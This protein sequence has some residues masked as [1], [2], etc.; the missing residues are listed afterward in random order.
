LTLVINFHTIEKMKIFVTGATGFVGSHLIEYFLNRG[1]TEII[2]LVRNPDNL[3]WLKGLEIGVSKG[4][5]FHIPDL[6]NDIDYVFHIAGLT[7]AS[8]MAD[9]YTVNQQGTA[10]LFRSLIS[11]GLKPKKVICL[12]SIAVSGPS[13]GLVPVKEESSPAPMTHYGKSKLEG[14]MEARKYGDA[15]PV[16]ILRVGAVYGPRDRDFLS[17]FNLVKKG[18]LPL[19][20][21]GKK[22]ISL[23]YVKD[24]AC[25][26]ELTLE[27]PV[28]G[29]TFHIADPEPYTWEEIGRT[30]GRLMGKDRIR[31][32]YIPTAAAYPVVYLSE[33]IGKL[34]SS[35]SI[36]NSQKLKEG[37]QEAWI[38]DVRKA[39]E[40]LGYSPLYTLQEGLRET[41]EWY[42]KTDWL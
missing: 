37:L 11:Q 17:L 2:A 26:F 7:K 25:A 22:W 21:R 28:F 14:E 38:V 39:K 10:S 5:L 16:V 32:V 30:A 12:S 35:P 13:S 19:W 29:E 20:G 31:R 24:L 23:C 41:L 6:P 42:R 3:K 9:Y 15:L 18:I 34:T 33:W 1:D 8:Q 4:D 40:R 27:K 36:V